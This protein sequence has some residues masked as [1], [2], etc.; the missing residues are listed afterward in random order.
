MTEKTPQSG[1]QR[2]SISGRPQGTALGVFLKRNAAGI[3]PACGVLSSLRS[4]LCFDGG[5]IGSKPVP[6]LPPARIAIV[7]SFKNA[8]FA[9]APRSMKMGTTPSPWQL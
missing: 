9:G 8:D 7:A 5:A 2:Y 4:L 3:K 1:K 6:P